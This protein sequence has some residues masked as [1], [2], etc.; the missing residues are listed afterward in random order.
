VGNAF[1]EH[2]QGFRAGRLRFSGDIGVSSLG[3]TDYP[4]ELIFGAG[5]ETF[6]SGAKIDSFRLTLSVNH[7]F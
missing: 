3:M 7:G 1:D 5:S 4:V 6:E 2:L